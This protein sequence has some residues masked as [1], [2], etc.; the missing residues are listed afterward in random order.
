MFDLDRFSAALRL[1]FEHQEERA[2][3][4]LD[5]LLGEGLDDENRGWVLI[6][7]ARFLGYLLRLAEARTRLAEVSR[8]WEKTPQHDVRIAVAEAVL[9]EAE[10]NPS[11]TLKE[12][13][14][15][16]ERYKGQWDLPGMDDPYEEIQ[17][18]RGRLLVGE[19]RCKEALP[20][21]EET[22]KF[23]RGKPGEF[24]FNLG[25]CYFVTEQWEESERWLKEALTKEL[26][27]A[28][29][30]I[31]HYYL[32]RLEHDRGAF[33]RAVK[34]FETS[35]EYARDAGISRKA[36]YGALAKAYKGLGQIEDAI[37][38]AELAVSSE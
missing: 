34:E 35:E 29:A 1:G 19:E 20:L 33:A 13:D 27:S 22:L 14:R 30:S 18:T 8:I 21:L 12:L 28:F 4:E 9:Y 15:I 37:H 17:A 3:S 25:Y 26:D 23:E 16:L 38:Y 24:Y 6:Y 11:R 31:T 2:I 7:Q 5:A 36:I 32:G 10:E